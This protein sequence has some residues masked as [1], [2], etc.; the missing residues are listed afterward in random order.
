MIQQYGN[1]VDDKTSEYHRHS[2][3]KGQNCF[4]F[5]SSSSTS[6]G[7][8]GLFEHTVVLWSCFILS[9]TLQVP[10]IRWEFVTANSCAYILSPN[11]MNNVNS[12]VWVVL[13]HLI[14]S[15]Q[16]RKSYGRASHFAAIRSIN[17]WLQN[18]FR[19]TYCYDYER[20]FLNTYLS[21]SYCPIQRWR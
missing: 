2:S 7:N 18:W 5:Y 8:V 12:P 6:G 15:W 19:L 10:G 3:F 4:G 17:I 13:T 21:I 14:C 16:G 1:A 20:E 11:T 9:A